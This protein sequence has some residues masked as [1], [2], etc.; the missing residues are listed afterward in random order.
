[1]CDYM[2]SAAVAKKD[3]DNGLENKS[4]K[5]P[6]KRRYHETTSAGGMTVA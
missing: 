2:D 4:V 3:K 6:K 1:M 5:N